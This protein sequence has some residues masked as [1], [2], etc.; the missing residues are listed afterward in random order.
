MEK[1][2]LNAEDIFENL[3]VDEEI[4]LPVNGSSMRPFLKSGSD[5]VY[6]KKADTDITKI[7]IG[8]I[9][10]FRRGNC[11]IMHRVVS[12]EYDGTLTARGDYAR[13]VETG[14]RPSDVKAVVTAVN[15]NG[16]K[17]GK[18]HPRWLFYSKVFNNPLV[19][20]IICKV[21]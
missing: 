14:I 17:I 19:R 6:L 12:L 9:I 13:S 11:Y 16:K 20:K 5:F 21:K 3:P 1:I 4:V 10:V 2:S 18:R 8:D 15:V 7:K